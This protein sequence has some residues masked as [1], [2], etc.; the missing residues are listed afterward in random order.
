MANGTGSL[1]QLASALASALS[2]VAEQIAPDSVPQWLAELG[3][4]TLPDLSGDA[5]FATTLSKA[6]TA[7]SALD[8]LIVTLI[9][10]IDQNDTAGT[11][12]AG[13]QVLTALTQAFTALDSIATDFTRATSGLP[14]AGTFATFATTI[15]ENALE[16]AIV[17]YLDVFSPLT[18][19]VLTALGL[20][21]ITIVP[22]TIGGVAT[23]VARRKLHLDQIG[24]F[25]SNPLTSLATIF[26]WGNLG[27]NGAALFQAIGDLFD[28]LNPNSVAEVPSTPDPDLGDLFGETADIGQQAITDRGPDPTF[29]WFAL[30]FAATKGINPPGIQGTLNADITS[31]LN[32]TLS[33]LSPNWTLS[34]SLSGGLAAATGIQLL[35][36]ATLHV[37]PPTGTASG[38]VG[39][40]LTGQSADPSTPFVIF[41]LTGSSVVQAAQVLASLAAGF[42]WDS[43]NNRATADISMEAKITKGQIIIDTSGADGFLQ[44]I[45]PAGGITMSFDFDLTWDSQHG[46]RFTGGA[47]LQVSIP[48]HLSLGPIELDSLGVGLTADSNGLELPITVNGSGTLGPISAEVEGIG[49]SLDVQFQRGNL[50]PV[51]LQVGFVPPTGLGLSIEADAVSGGGFVSFDSKQFQYAGGLELTIEMLQLKAFGLLNTKPEVSFVIIISADFPPIELG[52]GFA[53]SGV[54]GLLGVNRTMALDPLR[55][56]FRAHTLDDIVFLRGD[57]VSQAPMLIKGVAAIFPPLDAHFVIGPF[58]TITWSDPPLVSATLGII[59]TLP[60]PVALAILGA[61]VVAVPD[62][63]DALILLNL[64]V[65]GTW[66]CN[67]KQIAI[68]ASL[69]D[70]YVA[71]FAVAGD[72]AFRLNYGESPSFAISVGGLNPLFQPPPQFPTLKRMSISLGDGGNPGI[73]VQGYFAITANSVQFGANAVLTAEASGFG[74]HGSVS[75]DV[76]IIL[77]PFGFTIDLHAELDVLAGGSVVMSIHLDGLFSGPSPWHIH[78]DASFSILFF[79]VSVSIDATFGQS[80]GQQNLPSASTINPFKTALQDARN[81]SAVLPSDAGR[82]ATL[83]ATPPSSGGVV[84]HPLGQISFRQTVV[85]LNMQISKFGNATPSD[86]TFFA[87]TGVSL[88]GAITGLTSSNTLQDEF[89]DG[90]FIQ[91]SDQ[92]KISKPSYVLHDSGAVFS[93]GTI[94]APFNVETDVVYTTYVEDDPVAGPYQG[95]D[96]QPLHSTVVALS[97]T[98][99]SANSPRRQAGE[100]RYVKPG[101][102]SSI[103]LNADLYVVFSAIKQTQR[104]DIVATPASFYSVQAALNQYLGTHPS[105]TQNLQVIAAYE[106]PGAA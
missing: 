18:R 87:A 44:S 5:T 10:A 40:A 101:L 72:M 4:D 22:V 26:Q 47:G 79:S 6:V 61:I 56:A 100:Q 23:T 90:Q 71:A 37:I 17:K 42:A 58:V 105:E 51:Q 97:G 16:S 12:S 63:D 2:A 9:T 98:G 46:F 54:G 92:D 33:Q 85:P 3:L 19:R 53:L 29:D 104:T 7:I 43:A 93:S 14:G 76:L 74:V 59:I 64:D 35:P 62:P 41:G 57:I 32:L 31:A 84:V 103:G 25:I 11:V 102:I 65:L 27:F 80:G 49:F 21:E 73:S 99:A 34:L 48:L 45:L 70:S 39:L 24:N 67:A 82:V 81:W 96:Y 15:F 94:L 89:A 20:I 106:L 78:G 66:D 68:D 8:P 28:I 30:T 69:Y 88:N 91:M 75:F 55:A 38:S 52:F 60:D 13:A 83:A 86:G 1:E 36:P 77:T 50:G 95:P